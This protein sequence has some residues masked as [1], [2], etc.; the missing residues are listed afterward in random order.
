MVPIWSSKR[1]HSNFAGRH[2]SFDK[3]FLAVLV[4]SLFS[5]GTSCVQLIFLAAVTPI[6]HD[7]YNFDLSSPEYVHQFNQFLKVQ[8]SSYSWCLIMSSVF[9]RSLITSKYF[10]RCNSV[11]CW[12]VVAELGT[13]WR[14][15]VLF[16]NEKLNIP[17]DQEEESSQV[18]GSV[19]WGRIDCSS[20]WAKK[21][22]KV[23]II[24]TSYWKL[25]PFTWRL[26]SIIFFVGELS[27]D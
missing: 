23:F 4:C 2:S 8:K 17:T 14:S 22:R 13:F 11:T 25:F 27:R 19:S 16:G 7:F 26:E 1:R 24:V 9:G 12:I 5:I 15:F 3:L 20:V 18:K 21:C 6:L 10:T